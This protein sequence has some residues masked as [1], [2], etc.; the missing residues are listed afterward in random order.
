M[1]G[2]GYT[3]F[4]D[5][6]ASDGRGQYIDTGVTFNG[7]YG[8][9]IDY[10]YYTGG[11]YFFG[12]SDETALSVVQSKKSYYVI[13]PNQHTYCAYGTGVTTGILNSRNPDTALSYTS[14]VSGANIVY[15]LT[16]LSDSVTYT[17]QKAVQTFDCVQTAALF[18]VHQI[19]GY[20]A[21]PNATRLGRVRIYDDNDVLVRNFRPYVDKGIPGMLDVV[22]DVFSPSA[23]GV[24]FLYG[25]F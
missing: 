4:C 1:M 8:I 23:N 21:T 12:A 22:N 24:N 15:T 18:A 5:W 11:A 25:F 16:R 17:T 14:R 6:I 20:N 2:E 13:T 9:E 10:L 3:G 7:R 19:G